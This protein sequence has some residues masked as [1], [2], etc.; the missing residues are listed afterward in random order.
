[1]EPTM[2]G[3]RSAKPPAANKLKVFISYSRDDTAFA[4]E[5]VAG[6]E[7]DGGFEISIDR[8]SIREGEDWRARLGGL[9]AGADTVV[10]ILSP[11]SAVSSMCLWEVEEA[12]RLSKRILPVLAKPLAEVPG[13]SQLAAINYVRFDPEIDGRSRSF[14]S[15]LSKLRLALNTDL[16]WLREH[17]RL[18]LRAREWQ[19]AGRVENR[20]LS[21]ADIEHARLWL[22][23]QPDAAPP[24]T[25]LHRDYI[26]ASEQA[27][28]ARHS[29]ERK[30]AETL[31]TAITRTKRALKITALLALIAIVAGLWAL[32]ERQGALSQAKRADAAS[33]LAQDKT[34]IA[35]Q[36][37]ALALKEKERADKFV[38]LV[39]SNPAGERAMKKICT[40][41]I[42]VTTR[43]ATTSVKDVARQAQDRFWELYFGPMY[44]VEL[45]QRK[46]SNIDNSAIESAM[47]RY[48]RLLEELVR[49]DASLPHSSLCS[50]ARDVRD[51]CNRYLNLSVGEPCR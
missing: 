30:R 22:E 51:E 1:M 43:L 18:L 23:G 21:G 12:V 35:E 38:N 27:Q 29:E 50:M 33:E 24:S 16:D 7:Y 45:H 37:A 15:A 25:E 13:P 8:D 46:T 9:I 32:S 34:V 5:I 20:L 14:M 49:V 11:T 26:Q 6:L 36:N 41:A 39:S 2:A 47:V 31:Q 48:G 3:I 42:E 10:F 44:I 28:A 4:D 17:T 40:Q 19:A